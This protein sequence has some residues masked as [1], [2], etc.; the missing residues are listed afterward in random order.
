[1]SFLETAGWGDAR[2]DPLAGDASSRRYT[3]LVRPGG[4]AILMEDPEGD[5]ALFARLARHLCG[6]GLSA[7]RIL[8]EDH[9]S[10][11]MLIEDL[12]D[13]L[14]ARLATDPAREAAL[15]RVATEALVD[16]HRAPP[17]PGLP[18]A[19]P[20]HLTAMIDLACIHY[21]TAPDLLADLQAALL[22]LL[23]DHAQPAD[24][25]ILRDYHAENILLLPDRPGAAA[26]GLLDFQD[27]LVGHR[28]Y[29]LMSL[30][31]DARRDVAE[32][33][34]EACIAYYLDATRQDPE[35]FG[36]SFAVL[37]FQRNLR[38]LGIFARLARTRGKPHYI[39]LIPRVWGHLQRDLSHPV[40]APVKPLME[41]LPR[42]TDAHLESLRSPCPTP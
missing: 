5:T 26:A 8:A 16:L 31:E 30:L 38:I 25:M 1:M 28:A 9:A 22:P 27:A 2:H 12:G 34:R 13:D 18:V 10:G 21:A 32:E 42:P 35:R 14:L 11:H 19:T 23:T 7:P 36:A 17:P 6:L 37:G 41:A 20:E 33:T 3:R 15:Y 24:V 29:D 39:D 4:T 40:L